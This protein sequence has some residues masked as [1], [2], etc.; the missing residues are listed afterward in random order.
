[1]A[2]F[3]W[4]AVRIREAVA[5]HLEANPGQREADV[6]VACYGLAFKAD[7]DDLRESPAMEIVKALAETHPG[8]VLAVEPNIEALPDG[9]S[10]V[11]LVTQVE[12][13]VAHVHVL[14][15]GHRDFRR[16]PY[17]GLE[18]VDICGASR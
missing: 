17:H 12:A 6:T 9:L 2:S 4:R 14:L 10:D 16:N 15:V 3:T 11:E 7:I 1:L 5:R 18:I 8:R 13:A